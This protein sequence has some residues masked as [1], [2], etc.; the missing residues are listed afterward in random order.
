M[1]LTAGQAVQK[2]KNNILGSP[3]DQWKQMSP[4][5]NIQIIIP[6]AKPRNEFFL[7]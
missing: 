6:Q 1:Q 7:I 2:I 5:N 3:P 4:P